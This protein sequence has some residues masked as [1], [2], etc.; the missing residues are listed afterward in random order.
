MHDNVLL[1]H[2]DIKKSRSS[3][4]DINSYVFEKNTVWSFLSSGLSASDHNGTGD[5]AR[6]EQVTEQECDRLS[7]YRAVSNLL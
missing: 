6:M 7:L 2:L 4:A 3:Y 5:R 1:Q